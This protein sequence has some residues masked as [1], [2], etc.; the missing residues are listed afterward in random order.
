MDRETR[1]RFEAVADDLRVQI[2][3]GDLPVGKLLPSERELQE[4]YGVSR[5]TLR[6]ALSVL[7]ESGWAES[8]PNRGVVCRRG[9]SSRE[10]RRI[11]Y[12]DHRD[13]VHR[14]LFFGLHGH[15]VSKGLEMVHVN[16]QD[17]G[18]IGALRRA[19]DEGFA[20]AVVWPKTHAADPRELS[21]LQTKLAIVAVDH[22]IGGVYTDL[23]MNDHFMGA[24]LVVSHLLAL[25][26]KR[27]AISGNFTTSEDAQL[28]FAGYAAAL[29]EAGVPLV[30]YDFLF[31]SPQPHPYEDP[32]LLCYRLEDEDRPDAVF[33]LHDMSVPPIVNAI[34]QCGLS[35]PGD[36][37]VAGF[38][39]DL[40]FAV[41]G[42]GLTTIG[43]NW[44]SVAERITSCLS[45]RLEHPESPF[46]RIFVPT[47]L[48]VRGSCGAPQGQWS[49][50]EHEPSSVT[51]TRRM[52]PGYIPAHRASSLLLRDAAGPNVSRPHR[53]SY[54]TPTSE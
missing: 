19:A 49:T 39:N 25:G 27:I 26:R 3:S 30:A 2:Q 38:G 10:S 37:A 15:M 50:E 31:S 48:I 45:D 42:V 28:R 24:Q 51:V 13:S 34:L 20:G 47:H 43:M 1:R 7:V 41:D 23:V 11:A 36:V 12:I 52:I 8:R 21:E 54:T 32:R 22:S 14:S 18:T 17:M 53:V 16:S 46:R 4:V 35:V 44:D 33:V 6:R 5:S 29:T 40:P 9:R